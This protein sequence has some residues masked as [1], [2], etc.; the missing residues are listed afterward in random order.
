MDI[1]EGMSSDSNNCLLLTKTIYDLVHSVREC[2]MKLISVF[3]S[4]GFKENKSDPCL[5]SKWNQ[6][7][8]LITGINVN[9]CLVV[10][11]ALL[12]EKLILELKENGFN[13]KIENNLQ[14]YLTCCVAE[15]VKLNRILMLQPHLINNLQAN[16][17]KKFESKKFYRTPGILRLIFFVLMMRPISLIQ[18]F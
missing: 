18:K 10:R 17:G 16:S 2:Q 6:D 7:G 11:K 9:A 13:L 1:P 3:K 14:D 12:I 15:D 4:I 8:I 5:L